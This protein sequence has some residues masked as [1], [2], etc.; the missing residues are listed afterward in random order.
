MRLTYLVFS[1]TRIAAGTQ[2]VNENRVAT[3]LLL[4]PLLKRGG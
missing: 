2:L 3:L 4:L 1:P